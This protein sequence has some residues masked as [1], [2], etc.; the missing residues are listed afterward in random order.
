MNRKSREL[1][2]DEQALWDYVT[3]NVKRPYGRTRT[4]PPASPSPVKQQSPTTS[5]VEKGAAQLSP[6]Q[7]RAL[8]LGANDGIDRRT[9]QRF[10][11]GEM[12]I[13][14]RLDLHGLNL[15]QAESAVTSFIHRAAAADYRCVLVVMAAVWSF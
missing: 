10:A 13:D 14:A 6:P 1:S 5:R 11:R 3:R 15:A 9:A 12:T 7:P 8:V 2:A 4:P